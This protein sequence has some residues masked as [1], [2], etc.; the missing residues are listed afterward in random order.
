MPLLTE[1]E[2]HG[3]FVW[4]FVDDVSD[5]VEYYTGH[6]AA[7]DETPVMTRT[8]GETFGPYGEIEFTGTFPAGTNLSVNWTIR[9]PDGNDQIR[10]AEG[11]LP[12][13]CDAET[14]ALLLGQFIN[15]NVDTGGS[16]G[17]GFL[18]LYPAQMPVGTQISMGNPVLTPAP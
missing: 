4:T 17:G 10:G 1:V 11:D 2:N 9:D 13:P 16:Q 6:G 14:A 8:A 12:Y 18:R 3:E 15:G 5:P 7:F